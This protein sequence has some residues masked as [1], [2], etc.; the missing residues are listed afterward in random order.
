MKSLEAIDSAIEA[1]SEQFK[2]DLKKEYYGSARKDT[3]LIRHLVESRRILIN[4]KAG[5]K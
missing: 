5:E 1:A 4:E 3:E 2:T